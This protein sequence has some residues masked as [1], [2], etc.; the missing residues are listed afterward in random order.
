MVARSQIR[1]GER[2]S[3]GGLSA[4]STCLARHLPPS[5]LHAPV[6]ARR[7]HTNR[8]VSR[9]GPRITFFAKLAGSSGRGSPS[10][11]KEL[12]AATDS[13]SIP[14][15]SGIACR[16]TA[17]LSGVGELQSAPSSRDSRD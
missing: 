4:F 17:Q 16:V 3:E 11:Y 14:F 12:A 10:T 13:R 5:T 1:R 15:S 7:T 9:E 2:V 6:R 8:G